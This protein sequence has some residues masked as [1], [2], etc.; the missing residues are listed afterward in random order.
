MKSK[1]PM[2]MGFVL[3]LSACATMPQP[4]AALESARIAVQSAETDPNV[5]K[6]APLDLDVARKDLNNAENAALHHQDAET[7]Q[8]AYLAAQN[9]RLAQAHAAAKADDARVAAGQIERD[10]IMLAARTRE[11]DKANQ[12][13]ANSKQLADAALV[14]R[15]QANEDAARAQA[16][17]DALKAT[18]TPRGQVLTLGDV[19]F[20]TGRAEL[21]SGSGRK[22][23]QLAK[24]LAEHP[25]RRVQI[26]GFT[27][28]V[29]AD[30]YNEELSQRRANAVREALIAR[31]I[32]SSRIGTEGYGKGY[33][34]ASNS[35]SGGRQLNR[36]VEVVIG[37]E[38]GSPITP[39]T[40]I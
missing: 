35:D 5:N 2:G 15:D 16:E 13:A 1:L 19:L 3:A 39:R 11:A 27:D 26:D 9:A 10:Q 8:S 18:S 14:Q 22:L 23:D 12:A 31:G 34:V 38:N 4:N 30:S 6:Y 20:D 25:M 21:N 32:E 29:G 40:G 24:F 28:S 33:P 37:P 17:L 7:S 36:R